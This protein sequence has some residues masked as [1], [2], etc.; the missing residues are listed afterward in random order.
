MFVP[1]IQAESSTNERYKISLI[2]SAD[3]MVAH[4]L[5]AA[6]RLR[7]ELQVLQKAPDDADIYLKHNPDNLLQW[8]AWIRG[9]TD[10]PYEDGVFELDIRCGIDYPLAP[11][12]IKFV[13]KVC[14][15]GAFF[16]FWSS[17]GYILRV[18]LLVIGWS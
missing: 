18:A 5:A 17:F 12:S 11:P 16:L 13:T 7:K 2:F 8:K 3:S 10:T 4:S 14:F 6:K 1:Y 15:I 9:P